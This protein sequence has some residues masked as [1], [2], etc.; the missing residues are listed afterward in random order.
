MSLN[1]AYFTAFASRRFADLIGIESF[2]SSNLCFSRLKELTAKM[3]NVQPIPV[4]D[5][6]WK[7][8]G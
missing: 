6:F 8:L 3:I 5:V 1:P 4:D 7:N 2:D